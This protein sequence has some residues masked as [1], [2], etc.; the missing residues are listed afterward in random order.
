MGNIMP[1]GAA[2]HF[3]LGF[4]GAAQPDTANRARSSAAA[5]GLPLEMSPLA[6]QAWKIV[7]ILCQFDL[8]LA[9]AGAGVLGK[10]IQDE[11]S[12][13]EHPH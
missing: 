11:C 13:V 8:Q 7:F 1:D 6:G 5:A 9:V 3:Q 2:I 10:D 12:T 4:T